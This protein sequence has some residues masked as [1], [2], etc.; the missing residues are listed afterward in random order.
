M[1]VPKAGAPKKAVAASVALMARAPKA[2]V[3]ASVAL[4]AP[5][6][7]RVLAWHSELFG[8]SRHPQNL[9]VPGGGR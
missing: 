6:G 2:A 3:A 7:P 1:E 5:K 8:K 4:K 9:R